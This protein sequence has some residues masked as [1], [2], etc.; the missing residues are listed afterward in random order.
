MTVADQRLA[1]IVSAMED[2]AFDVLSVDIFDTLLWRRVPEPQDMFVQ[3]AAAL[4]R[5]EV[6]VQAVSPVQFS[7]LRA[8]AEKSARAAAEATSGSREVLLL[9]IY[10]HLPDHIW[11]A[12]DSRARAVLQEVETEAA[13]MILDEDVAALVRTV[14]DGGKKVILTSDTYFTRDQLIQFLKGAGLEPDTLPEDLYISNEHGRPKWRDLFDLVLSDLGIAAN[15]LVHVGDN[16]DADV[17]PCAARGIGYVHYDKWLALP[18]AQEHEFPRNTTR[19]ADWIAKGGDGGLTGLRSRLA[20]RPPIDMSS[21]AQPY[22]VYGATVLAPLFAAYAYWVDKTVAECENAAVFGVMREGRF[23]ARLIAQVSDTLEPKELWL[24]RRAV[25]RASLW[26]DDLSALPQAITY[27]PGPTTDDILAQ[28][29]LTRGDLTGVF[30]DPALFDMHAADGVQAFLQG[31]AASAELQNKLA[32]H[33]A[34]L[35]DNLLTYLDGVIDFS[36]MD[37]MALLDLG[38]AGTIQTALQTILQREGREVQLTGLYVAVNAPGMERVLSGVD[39]RALLGRDGFSG[40]LVRLLERTPDILEHACMCREGSLD[41]FDDAGAPVLL[42]SQ[43][44]D[45][46]VVQMEAMQD[47]ILNG[48][49][50]CMTVLGPDVV[51]SSAFLAHAAEIV[52]QAM[53]H[54]TSTDV[55]TIGGWLHEANFDL[56][57]QRAL[58]DLRVD[59]SQ[60]EFGGP[61]AWASLGRYEAY[62]PQAALSRISPDMAKMSAAVAGGSANADVLS[63]G[64]IFGEL[65]VIPDFGVGPEPNRAVSAPLTASPLGRAEIRMA[66]KSFGPDALKSFTVAWPSVPSIL[67]VALCGLVFQGESQQNVADLTNHVK[68]AGDMIQQRGYIEVGASGATMSVDLA[69]ATV[70][71]PHQLDLV[72]RFTYARLGRMM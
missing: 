54:P 18:R 55:Q 22:W 23:L 10:A 8:A 2:D 16:I 44:P 29:G 34:R 50:A 58:A 33:S 48:V 62:W 11:L 56:A 13:V 69:S 66:V 53:L 61:E 36:D 57:D 4:H 26:P 15:R 6:L 38:Y 1:P 30:K 60:L 14:R 21:D 47:G 40:D 41:S 67:S 12:D 51:G 46:Q 59:A 70:P 45:A 19:R 63:S 3:V 28:L 37:T 49:R 72:L 24:S 31:V 27:C 52:R 32:S 7:E 64:S 20:H 17:A 39:L 9:D 43:R 65:V 25:V 42:P 68:Y 5:E 35:R 71:W